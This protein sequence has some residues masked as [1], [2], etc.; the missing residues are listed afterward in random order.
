MTIVPL[1]VPPI[2]WRVSVLKRKIAA[3]GGRLLSL[4]VQ[5][6]EAAGRVLASPHDRILSDVSTL[7]T[8]FRI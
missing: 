6:M 5:E 7:G 4:A 8:D 3:C 2:N 1:Y